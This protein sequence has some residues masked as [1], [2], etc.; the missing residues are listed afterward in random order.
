MKLGELEQKMME[1]NTKMVESSV[2]T[3][4]YEIIAA[5][6]GGPVSVEFDFDT[7][8][9]YHKKPGFVQERL[10]WIHVHPTGI[11]THPSGTDQDC[12]RGLNLAFGPI[13]FGLFSIVEFKDQDINSLEGFQSTY[14][15]NGK[16]LELLHDGNCEKYL[17]TRTLQVLKTLSVVV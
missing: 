11:G 3:Y 12:A 13:G 1:W 5:S 10:R 16:E 14:K 15:F 7:V 8:W 4:Y 17:D 2:V 9:K 6:R